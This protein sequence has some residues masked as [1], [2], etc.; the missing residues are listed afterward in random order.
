MLNNLPE[1]TVH[2]KAL[3]LDAPVWVTEVAEFVRRGPSDPSIPECTHRV[4]PNDLF[5]LDPIVVASSSE[6][7]RLLLKRYMVTV[8][9]DFRLC[10]V[11]LAVAVLLVSY[12][13]YEKRKIRNLE[14]ALKQRV[15]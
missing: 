2:L 3:S 12:T 1:D 4:T 8:V 14:N 15:V 5:S 10:A 11:A 9:H 7:T 13:V 6:V